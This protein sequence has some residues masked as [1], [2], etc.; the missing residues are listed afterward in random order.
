[1]RPAPRQLFTRRAGEPQLGQAGRHWFLRQG[2]PPPASERAPRVRRALQF[3][4]HALWSGQDGQGGAQRALWSGQDGQ[5]GA[6]RALW[7]GLRACRPQTMVQC[8]QG[9]PV[10]GQHATARVWPASAIGVSWCPPWIAILPDLQPGQQSTVAVHRRCGSG[11][12]GAAGHSSRGKR[13][14]NTVHG[15]WVGWVEGGRRAERRW[16]QKRG[17]R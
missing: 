13:L 4:R 5:G 8:R 16:V 2:S 15:G 3:A 11:P 9:V 6:Q 10:P 17:W 1:M 7:S 14:C 12:S